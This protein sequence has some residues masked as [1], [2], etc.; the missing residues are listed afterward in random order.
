MVYL[1]SIK[2]KDITSD[3]LSEILS[4][5]R[6]T[7]WSFKKKITIAKKNNKKTGKAEAADGWGALALISVTIKN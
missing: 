2:D 3:E 5:R 1:V 6:E 7:C 4:L